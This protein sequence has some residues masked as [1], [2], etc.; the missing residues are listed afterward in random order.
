VTDGVDLAA[1]VEP[2]PRVVGVL[3]PLDVGLHLHD[4]VAAIVVA[5]RVSGAERVLNDV[6]RTADAGERPLAF[7]G[8]A[9]HRLDAEPPDLPDRIG[10]GLTRPV[11]VVE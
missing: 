7:T 1:A 8:P 3:R 4:A 11:H 9:F 5:D 2:D 10:D 6:C